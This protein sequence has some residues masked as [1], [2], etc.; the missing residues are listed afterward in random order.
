LHLEPESAFDVRRLSTQNGTWLV[1]LVHPDA[2]PP[3]A[4]VH[5]AIDPPPPPEVPAVRS[6]EA[7]V[8]AT[9]DLPR[10]FVAA[11]AFVGDVALAIAGPRVPATV[12]GVLAVVPWGFAGFIEAVPIPRPVSRRI[13]RP[14]EQTSSMPMVFGLSAAA[15]SLLLGFVAKDSQDGSMVAVVGFNLA[16]GAT[17]ALW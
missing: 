5:A 1:R 9:S 12:A 8:E 17:F 4:D 6:V 3:L 14:G 16:A 7:A 10:A 11:G 13:S 15:A 2:P